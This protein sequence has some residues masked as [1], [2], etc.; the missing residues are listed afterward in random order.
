M[1]PRMFTGLI[2][3]VGSVESIA[4]VESGARIVVAGA[5]WDHRPEPG[6]S[7]AVSGCCLTVSEPV[8][9][10]GRMVFDVVAETL[11]RTT[12]GSLRPGDGVNLERSL[13]LG[14]LVG[15]H[16]VQGHVDGVGRV[17]RI[18]RE[19]GWR[20]R[21]QVPGGLMEFASP[22]GSIAIEGV[23]LTI[24]GLDPPGCSVEVVLIPTTLRET[25]LDSLVEGGGV[26]LEMDVLAKTV[27][28]WARHYAPAGG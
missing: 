5:G 17:R 15:G 24:A 28:H 22:K 6:E 11:A 19:D 18:D 25:T 12:L 26:N 20:V 4:R 9:G 8:G 1:I 2:Q 23:S 3:H 16:I 13:T 14:S 7:I 10:G 21:I 27:I